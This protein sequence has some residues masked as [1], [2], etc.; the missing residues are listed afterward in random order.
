MVTNMSWKNRKKQL[1]NEIEQLE[2]R[3][4]SAGFTL[5]SMTLTALRSCDEDATREMCKEAEDN[6]EKTVAECNAQLVDLY[7]Q[8]H[9]EQ[10]MVVLK[11]K[12][13]KILGL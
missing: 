4:V 13:K 5:I 7:S 10:P 8:L 12:I 11:T 1:L 9:Y 3:K 6:Y 2:A